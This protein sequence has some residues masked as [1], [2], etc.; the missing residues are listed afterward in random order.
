MSH[1]RLTDVQKEISKLNRQL[2]K[3]HELQSDILNL[4]KKTGSLAADIEQL[5]HQRDDSATN[6][7]TISWDGPNLKLTWTAGYVK[8][9]KNRVY[10]IPAGE[11]TGLTA[12]TYYWLG[13]NPIHETMSV[14]TALQQLVDI[15]NILVIA[16]VFTG[17]NVQTGAA[18]GG[19][20]CTTCGGSDRNS[21]KYKQF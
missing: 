8:D 20:G 16:Q 7:L 11:R 19:G 2:A 18:G 21:G 5:G 6:N 14:T 17:T 13:W 12:S 3:F 1:E 10:Q 9:R 4:K 15:P